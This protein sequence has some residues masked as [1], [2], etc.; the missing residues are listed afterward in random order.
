[1]TGHPQKTPILITHPQASTS[2]PQV[3]ASGGCCCG[4]PILQLGAPTEKPWADVIAEFEGEAKTLCW[5]VWGD[6]FS[7]PMILPGILKKPRIKGSQLIKP[8]AFY[9]SC[10]P[11]VLNAAKNSLAL[12]LVTIPSYCRWF[13]NPARKPPEMSKTS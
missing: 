6:V 7:Y 2:G 10:Q 1:M 11:S 4:A 9:G 5:L 8:P 13:R 12:H 3:F